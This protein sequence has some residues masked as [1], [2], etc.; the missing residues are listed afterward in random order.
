MTKFSLLKPL[1]SKEMRQRANNKSRPID[2][3][4]KK[5]RFRAVKATNEESRR[6]IEEDGKRD[7][8]GGY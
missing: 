7:V 1:V 4:E 2:S 6:K 5:F 8:A 3:R